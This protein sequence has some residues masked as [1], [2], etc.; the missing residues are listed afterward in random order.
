VFRASKSYNRQ[1]VRPLYAVTAAQKSLSPSSVGLASSPPLP[2]TAAAAMKVEHNPSRKI[3]T[4]HTPYDIRRRCCNAE[5]SMH[6]ERVAAKISWQWRQRRSSWKPA[7]ED[8]GPW[9]HFTRHRSLPLHVPLSDR[10]RTEGW[11][12]IRSN[13]KTD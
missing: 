1:S 6:V 8:C 5:H 10:Q 3:Y 12:V 4:Q 13:A 11:A 2:T 7:A 9:S